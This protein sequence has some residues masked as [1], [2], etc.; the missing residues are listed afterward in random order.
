MKETTNNITNIENIAEAI[1]PFRKRTER[2]IGYVPYT[3][4]VEARRYNGTSQK[5]EKISVLCKTLVKLVGAGVTL[6]KSLAENVG[7]ELNDDIE[8]TLF[9]EAV[10]IISK[11]LNLVTDNDGVYALTKAGEDYVK[12]GNCVRTFSKNF[13]LYSTPLNYAN[14][15]LHFFTINNPNIKFGAMEKKPDKLALNEIQHICEVQASHVH[16]PQDGLQLLRA[17]L[18]AYS[19][20]ASEVIVCLL[21]RIKDNSIR[22]LVYV[23]GLKK[24]VPELSSIFTLDQQLLESLLKQCLRNEILKDEAEKVDSGEKPE[25]QVA[26]EEKVLKEEEEG[27]VEESLPE[28]KGVGSIYDS[29]EFEAELRSIFRDHGNDEIW[30]ISPWIRD[31]AFLKIREPMI[32]KFLSEGGSVFIGYSEP[33][34]YGEE[35]VQPGSMSVVKRLDE[36]F[37]NFYYAELPKFHFKNVIEFKKGKTTLF[38]GSFNILSFSIS[39]NEEHYRMEQMIM[40]NPKDAIIARQQYRDAFLERYLCILE[41][42][43]ENAEERTEVFAGKVLRLCDDPGANDRIKAV[44]ENA[45]NKSIQLVNKKELSPA[46][47]LKLVNILMSRPIGNNSQYI[48][49][50][51][52]AFIYGIEQAK[53]SHNSPRLQTIENS[54]FKFLEKEP[55]YKFCRLSMRKSKENEQKTNISLVCNKVSFEFKELTLPNK[56]F[57]A[58]F[59]RK[60]F[61]D[62]REER[63]QNAVSSITGILSRS[64]KELELVPIK[65]VTD[66]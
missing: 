18:L 28:T 62:F 7:L 57:K 40:A 3:L 20:T 35:M 53:S 15:Y 10:S 46:E 55:L 64:A 44:V 38:T 1:L 13:E 29:V 45:N 8:E 27:I 61:I 22:A 66:K 47:L 6:R 4:Q 63:I 51:L 59:K 21:Q 37:D 36:S 65:K 39:G 23:P 32:K 31:Y 30:M 43:V 60:E 34:K 9:D 42:D 52:A 56:T 11:K 17:D 49:A 54:L 2:V 5:P 19:M 16:S 12:T 33:E 48:Q 24:V 26:Y 14:Q 50:Q 41:D 25:E 58:L